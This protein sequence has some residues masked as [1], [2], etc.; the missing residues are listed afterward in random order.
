MQF[1]L[2]HIQS[3]VLKHLVQY[4]LFNYCSDQSYTG[5]ITSYPNTNYCLGIVQEKLLA[6]NGANKYFLKDKPGINS[7]ITGI[8]TEPY[9]FQANGIQDEICIDFTPLGYYYF[10]PFNARTFLL[11]NDIISEAFGADARNFFEDI[12]SIPNFRKRGEMIEWF[13]LKKLNKFLNNFLA[14]ALHLICKKKG[15]L[16]V[17][18][19][20]NCSERKLHQTFKEKLD[21]STKEFMRITRFRTALKLLRESKKSMTSHAYDLGFYDQ[22]HFIKEM[23]GLTGKT[24][25]KIPASIQGIENEVWITLQNK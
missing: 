14:E 21:I 20:L 10:F 19:L 17:S 22:R 8:Y 7:Y 23:K 9:R 6:T 16:T 2:H 3:P 12:F 24:P 18:S 15:L 5:M 25:H 13:L 4:I 11:N 1:Y